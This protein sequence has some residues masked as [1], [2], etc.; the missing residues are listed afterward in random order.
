[1]KQLIQNFIVSLS[2]C[3]LVIFSWFAGASSSP[4]MR[5]KS[6][7]DIYQ[8][9]PDPLPQI[10]MSAFYHQAYVNNINPEDGH[11]NIDHNEFSLTPRDDIN[12]PLTRYY[13]SGRSAKGIG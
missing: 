11:L 13:D 10:P 1:M 6:S 9:S 4:Q 12:L 8:Y 5:M 3:T 7:P 2:C